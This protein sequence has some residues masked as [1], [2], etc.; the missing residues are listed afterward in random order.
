M[1]L[2]LLVEPLNEIVFSIAL[3][4]KRAEYVCFPA[5]LVVSI[6]AKSVLPQLLDS[7]GEYLKITV[8]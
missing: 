4:D 1:L 7:A 5:G 8:S 3:A 2:H 6:N